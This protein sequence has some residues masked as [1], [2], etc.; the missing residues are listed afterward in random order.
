M[1]TIKQYSE[2]IGKRFGKLVVIS[3]NG[4]DKRNNVLWLCQCDC[5]NIKI[6]LDYSLKSGNTKSCGCLRW[7]I[8]DRT[9]KKYGSL[10]VIRFVKR[11][12]RKRKTWWLC[13]CN[14]GKEV[15]VD[16]NSLE[17]GATKSCGCSR[18]F[19]KGEAAFRGVFRRTKTSAK[20][21]GHEFKLTEKDV[22]EI[23]SK[24]C[25]YCGQTPLS[26]AIY[27][28]CY[29]TY[30]YNGIDRVDNSIGYIKENCV[31]CCKDCNIGKGT[32]TVTEFY[33]WIDRVRKHKKEV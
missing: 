29:G 33:E 7:Q 32:K 11:D 6:V 13:E 20:K 22:K 26:E 9:G 4:K 21:R 8:K 16:G 18:R 2:L 23:H 31:S 5:G 19:A 10:A 17:T 25:F 1:K 27:E 30:I 3:Y 15:V 24:P 14:C 12:K 28:R